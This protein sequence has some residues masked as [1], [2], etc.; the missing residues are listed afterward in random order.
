MRNPLYLRQLKR[1]LD[2]WI[3]AGLVDADCADEIL[4][5]SANSWKPNC[6]WLAIQPAPVRR[7]FLQ[8][9]FAIVDRLS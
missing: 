7:E 8:E 9:S 1:D 6:P 5:T 2:H 3:N 4:E